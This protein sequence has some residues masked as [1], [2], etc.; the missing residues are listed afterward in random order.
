MDKYIH[1]RERIGNFILKVTDS[2]PLNPREDDNITHMVC[3]HGRYHLGD[4]HGYKKND[5]NSWQ[6]LF[7]AIVEAEK[8][9]IIQPL[10]MYE[11]GGITISTSKFR[12]PWDSGQIGFVYITHESYKAMMGS[13]INDAS[14]E[15]LEEIIQHE[16]EDY[17][18]YVR[19]EAYAYEIYRIVPDIEGDE[20][21]KLHDSCGGFAD[22][23]DAYTE[24]KAIVEHMI[25]AQGVE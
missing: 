9:F 6:E 3:F 2:E 14:P 7:Q 12:D 1:R 18:R 11:H 25:Q 13:N 16:V 19:G 15:S 10:F 24:G 21:E 4:K 23:D 5:Y 22:E 8:P 17:D 20:H